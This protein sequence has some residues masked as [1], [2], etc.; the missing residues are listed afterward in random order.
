M[1]GFS[2]NLKEHGQGLLANATHVLQVIV[3]ADKYGLDLKLLKDLEYCF[4]CI[5]GK[6][7]DAVIVLSALKICTIGPEIHPSLATAANGVISTKMIILM[8]LPEWFEWAQSVPVVYMEIF[9]EASQMKMLKRRGLVKTC[10]A[11]DECLDM[12]S[13]AT[14]E[15]CSCGNN[16]H[17]MQFQY[18][19]RG[20]NE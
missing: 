11:C 3:T 17:W 2:D 5:V 15:E 6:M 18:V 19:R 9:E 10:I 8:E 14:K 7:E 12:D 16:S 1:Y 4:Q 13:I 20:V